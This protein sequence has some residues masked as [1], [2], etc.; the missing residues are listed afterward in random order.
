LPAV[1]NAL[2]HPL[3]ASA[4][5]GGRAAPAWLGTQ[6]GDDPLV[7]E[8]LVWVPE[9]SFDPDPALPLVAAPEVTLPLPLET[10][11]PLPLGPT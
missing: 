10:P 11:E 8:P 9:V 6:A 5:D 3:Q 4:N 7:A 2:W 1:P